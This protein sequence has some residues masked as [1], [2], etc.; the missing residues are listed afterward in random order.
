[1]TS[2]ERSREIIRESHVGFEVEPAVAGHLSEAYAHSG[3]A[4]RA[5]R[6][7]EEAV[8]GAR[9]RCVGIVP[10]V[11]LQLAKVLLRTRGLASR[12]AIEA[13]LEETSR[14]ARQIGYKFLDPFIRLERAELARLAHDEP[15]R[16]RELREAYRLFLEMGAPIRAEQVARE[17]AG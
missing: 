13:A 9:Q 6:T 14:V 15:T 11:Q 2:L 4:D 10:V 16:Q 8:R 5:L 1:M 17:L 12:S 7:A 3:E